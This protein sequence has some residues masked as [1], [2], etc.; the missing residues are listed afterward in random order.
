MICM[1][2]LLSDGRKKTRDPFGRQ[3]WGWDEELATSSC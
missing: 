1:V 3:V 2:E